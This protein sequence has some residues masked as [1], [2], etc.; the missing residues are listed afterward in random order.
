MKFGSLNGSYRGRSCTRSMILKCV[1]TKKSRGTTCWGVMG[2][3]LSSIHLTS[4]RKRISQ[5][6]RYRL[7]GSVFERESSGTLDSY[8]VIFLSVEGRKTEPGYFEGL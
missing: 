3:C 2:P 7:K 1:M 5:M 4:S 8:R 6:T